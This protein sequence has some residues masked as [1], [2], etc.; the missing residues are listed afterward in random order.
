MKKT[1]D[2][3]VNICDGDRAAF[4][5]MQADYSE[6][7]AM[8]ESQGTITVA[9]CIPRQAEKLANATMQR[10]AAFFSKHGKGEGAS[11]LSAKSRQQIDQYVEEVRK[12]KPADLL[13]M[14]KM[15]AINGINLKVVDDPFYD[16][17]QEG[18]ENKVVVAVYLKGVRDKEGKLAPG[19]WELKYSDGSIFK[20][21]SD[22]NDCGYV[23][24]RALTNKSVQDLRNEL[25][26]A[27]KRDA[28]SFSQA[29]E[30]RDW[31]SSHNPK[32]ANKLLFNGGWDEHVHLYATLQWCKDKGFTPKQATIIAQACNLVDTYLQPDY[33]VTFDLKE[34]QSWHFNNGEGKDYSPRDTRIIHAVNSLNDAIYILKNSQDCFSSNRLGFSVECDGNTITIKEKY[35]SGVGFIFPTGMTKSKT[36]YKDCTPEQRQEI[37]ESIALRILG[38]GLHPLQDLHAH[39]PD[40]VKKAG[41]VCYH[42][43]SSCHGGG[44]DDSYHISLSEHS[45]PSLNP[46]HRAQDLNQRYTVTE[47]STKF[48]LQCFKDLRET[49]YEE[50]SSMILE[51]RK[52]CYTTRSASHPRP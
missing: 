10:N 51:E 3:G 43:P 40:Y 41:S 52:T 18:R 49:T 15:A 38:E 17:T 39:T 45:P 16:F 21:L 13:D 6:H 11:S 34:I 24:M 9:G 50:V 7:E 20:P 42:L 12:G 31:L 32:E 25:A 28:S 35:A 14:E 23:V 19:H 5:N 8:L 46:E 22:G 48:Y 27:I 1:N 33:L 47:E 44:A 37:A 29:I 2:K 26:D 4:R 30:A 36:V